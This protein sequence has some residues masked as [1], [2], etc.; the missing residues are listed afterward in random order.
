MEVKYLYSACI[1]VNCG[2]FKILTD[3]WFTDGA[4]DGAW[5]Q[6]PK[7]NPF[8]YITKPDLIYISHIHPDH[9][10]PTFL[11]ELIRRFGDVKI[12][13]PDL[14]P[15]YLVFKGKSDGL[16]LIPT[17]HFRNDKVE[18]FIEENDTGSP[19]DI[20]SALIIREL[21]TGQLLLNL[22]DCIYN[23][24]HVDTLQAI[25]KN[26][27]NKIDLLALGYTGAGPYPQTYIDLDTQKDMLIS[28]ADKK[29]YSFFERYKRYTKEFVASFNLPFA[30]EYILG[31][32]QSYLNDYRGVSDAFEIK[33]IDENAIVLSNGGNINLNTKIVENERTAPY[34]KNKLTQRIDSVKDEKYDYEKDIFI[35]IDK[36]NFM[37]LIKAAAIKAKYKSELDDEYHFIFSILDKDSIIKCRFDL[38]TKECSVKPL[39]INDEIGYDKFSEIKIDYRYFYGLLTTIYHWNNAEVGSHYFTNRHPLDNYESKV[40]SF[41]NFFSIA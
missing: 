34:D 22:N 20:D 27:G 18:L 15:N 35:S 11:K 4:Y 12:L 6:F 36:I 33:L 16:D 13:I 26:N 31:G 38:N 41:L 24:S 23:Q 29:K 7:I 17:R 8:Q 28:E 21:S 39:E 14:D 40:Q 2:G 10:D 9:Y 19:S 25:I 3:P 30:G 37:R 5:Y 32:K 1:E